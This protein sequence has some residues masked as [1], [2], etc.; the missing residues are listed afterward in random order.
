MAKTA[1]KRKVAPKTQTSRTKLTVLEINHPKIEKNVPIPALRTLGA[2]NFIE[3]MELGDSFLIDQRKY[4]VDKA[5]GAV[6]SKA[7]TLGMKVT[8][9]TLLDGDKR[10]WRVQ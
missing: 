7:D 9:R 2:W 4:D 8:I 1:K 3:Q 6:R 10:V 5:A